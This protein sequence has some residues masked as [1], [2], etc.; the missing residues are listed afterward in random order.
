MHSAVMSVADR[1]AFTERCWAGTAGGRQ[2]ATTLPFYLG[3][4]RVSIPE[5]L[6][7]FQFHAGVETGTVLLLS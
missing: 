6:V 2:A 1:R 3:N 4:N 7:L 5:S